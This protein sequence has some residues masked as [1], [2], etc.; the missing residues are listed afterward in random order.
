MWFVD[1]ND[2]RVPVLPNPDGTVRLVLGDA[3]QIAMCDLLDGIMEL[4]ALGAWRAP[5]EH[6]AP[7]AE[8][9]VQAGRGK[10][11]P[12]NWSSIVFVAGDTKMASRYYSRDIAHYRREAMERIKLA[13]RPATTGCESREAGDGSAPRACPHCGGALGVGQ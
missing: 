8:R 4:R 9:V 7:S 10:W 5:N 12:A 2:E 11:G 1:D 6:E 3:D 13:A